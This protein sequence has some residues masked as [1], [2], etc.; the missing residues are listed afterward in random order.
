[1][2][3]PDRP[4]SRRGCRPARPGRV[5]S[6]SGEGGAPLMIDL[7]LKMLLDEKARFAATV[8]GVGFAAALVLVQV[9][10]F[11]GL[12]E[13]ASIT[14]DRLDPDPWSTPSHTPT[15]PFATPFPPPPLHR[16]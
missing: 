10:L 9:G 5:G 6:R 15:P 13:N 16:L 2:D 11:F 7:A 8:L 4:A 3:V 12:L 1:A 14:I